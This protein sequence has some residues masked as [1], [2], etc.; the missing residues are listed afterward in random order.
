MA[1]YQV[2]LTCKLSIHASTSETR[3][4]TVEASTGREAENKALNE[5]RSDSK[6]NKA[7]V[8]EIAATRLRG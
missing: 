8:T 7:I 6:Y 5:L 2:N 1:K 3:S 4:F